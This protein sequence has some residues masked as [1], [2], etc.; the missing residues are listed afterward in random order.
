MPNAASTSFSLN[1]NLKVNVL[2]GVGAS[3][4]ERLSRLGI[5]TVSDLLRHYPRRYEDY[6]ATP[7]IA[8]LRPGT[9]ALKATVTHLGS[10]WA[11]T[12]R[13]HITEAVISDDS[14]STKA[15]WFNQ[16]YL[17][18]QL[19]LGQTYVFCGK[20]E[21]KG[22][23]ALQSPLWE[24][25]GDLAV[26]GRI[27]PIYG[28]TEG[29]TSRM[30][31][32]VMIPSLK[33]V[34]SLTSSLP[35]PITERFSLMPLP[36]ALT[37][38]HQPTD[39]TKLKAARTRLAFDELFELITTSL[40]IKRD[41][42]AEPG[43]AIPFDQALARRFVGSL[44]FTLTD[45]QR[46]AA[47]QILQDLAKPE[48]MNRL[49]EGD[50]GSGKTVVAAMA[51]LI[52][53]KQG[54]QTALIVP[55]EILAAQHF[56]NLQPMAEQFGATA[57]QLVGSQ[58]ATE[59]QA[60]VQRLAAGQINLLIGT[61]ALLSEAVNFQNLGLVVIDEQHRFG[62][63]QRQTLKAKSD[64][65][66]HLLS[67]TATPIPRSLMLAVYG[68][69]DISIIRQLP[70]GR[71]SIITQ[72]VPDTQRAAVYHQ[73][74]QQIESG[75]Q[76]FVVCPL[77]AESDKLGVRSA[78]GEY[79]RLTKTTFSHR[80]I[81]LLHGKLSADDKAVVM[82]R[83]TSGQLDMLV[84]TSII[85]I[86]IDVP[87]ATIMMIEGADRFGLAA[88]HQLRGRVGRGQHQSYCFLLTDNLSPAVFER[89]GAME[90]TTDGF[91]LAEIDLELRGPGEIYGH[92][93]HGYMTLKLAEAMQPEL[94]AQVRAAAEWFLDHH[95]LTDYPNLATR[96][97][98]LKTITSLD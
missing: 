39:Q 55:T 60:V 66:P 87:N 48:P 77:V 32:K 76:V 1:S 3:L 33:Y 14:G 52:A 38:I 6:S 46:R 16:P 30:L 69:L 59:K 54:F 73:V 93:Q 7:T 10:R 85:E 21:F 84:A 83:F 36:E 35:E 34:D 43:V 29:L 56:K 91:K 13:L 61:H 15:V 26:I 78:Q 63:A 24:P 50:V 11:R 65:L 22:D 92:R 81:G 8:R 25:A 17:A 53:A 68:D 58:T 49:L 94:I 86:G 88:L 31:A 18:R 4:V 71:Q 74:D 90:E 2:P 42:K 70:A 64:H 9:V 23:L 45:D 51:A 41:L 44:P 19:K 95:Q 28:E 62:V 20:F 27:L 5:E 47:W 37:E 67:M 79:E 57:A 82:Q 72:V 97:Q 12:R 96:V 98:E 80:R 89:L 40:I 75:R